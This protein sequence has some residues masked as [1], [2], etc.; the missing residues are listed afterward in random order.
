MSNQEILTKTIEKAIAGGFDGTPYWT[1]NFTAQ[2][3]T[4]AIYKYRNPPY[5]QIIFNHDFAKA[6]WGEEL[7]ES[8]IGTASYLWQYRLQQMVIEHDPIAYLEENI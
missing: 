1:V 5:E 6:L 7:L 4:K 2:G 3:V 8:P